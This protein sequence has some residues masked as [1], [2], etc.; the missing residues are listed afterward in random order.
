MRFIKPST[1]TFVLRKLVF[2][3]AKVAIG[4]SPTIKSDQ[5]PS[6]FPGLS[7]LSITILILF[8]ISIVSS[9]ILGWCFFLFLLI[10]LVIEFLDP[11]SD[12][13]QMN[14]LIALLT[15]PDCTALLDRVLA[16]YTILSALG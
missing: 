13:A 2:S 10:I 5:F 15:V 4:A 6:D 1:E 3:I 9:F 16:D 14:G 12:A 11:S 8:V 7:L